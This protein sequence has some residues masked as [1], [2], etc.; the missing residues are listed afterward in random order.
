MSRTLR[1]F[2]FF[3]VVFSSLFVFC[4]LP[5]W[6]KDKQAGNYPLRGKVLSSSPE[7]EYFYQVE[8]DSRVYLMKCEKVPGLRGSM[9]ECM[10]DDRAIM[11]GDMLQFRVEGDWAYMPVAKGEEELRIFTTELKVIPPL[12]PPTASVNGKGSNPGEEHGMVIGIGLHTKGQENVGWFTSL[13]ANQPAYHAGTPSSSIP[14][15]PVMSSAPV[16]ATPVTGGPPVIMTPTAPTN[17]N[18][19]TG[20]PVTGGPPVTGITMGAPTGDGPPTGSFDI[21]A[22]VAMLR[23]MHLHTS[24]IR[25][26]RVRVGENIYQLECSANS[27]ELDKKQI[28]LGDTLVIRVE[29]K[30]AYLSSGSGSGAKEQKFRIVTDDDAN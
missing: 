16:I 24:W 12:P 1:S 29:N 13:L 15:G 27:C 26:L 17:G 30:W 5:S 6:A 23:G 18:I 7:G 20:I 3:S 11:N 8:T 28:E 21:G 22:G 14:S 9:P 25:L 10:F 2:S 4:L 19:V